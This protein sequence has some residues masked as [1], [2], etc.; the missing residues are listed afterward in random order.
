MSKVNVW[1]I[2]DGTYQRQQRNYK[3]L[4]VNGNVS[5]TL[6]TVNGCHSSDDIFKHCSKIYWPGL[7]FNVLLFKPNRRKTAL[8]GHFWMLWTTTSLEFLF[9]NRTKASA[10]YI[11]NPIDGHIQPWNYLRITLLE[12]NTNI[13]FTLLSPAENCSLLWQVSSVAF[14]LCTHPNSKFVWNLMILLVRNKLYL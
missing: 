9:I 6:V 10:K 13:A 5:S 8:P 3:L 7:M 2:F 1:S 14:T 4:H 12:Q 11:N